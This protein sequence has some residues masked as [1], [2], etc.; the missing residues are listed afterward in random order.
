VLPDV[1]RERYLP[2]ARDRSRGHR[3][4]S[5]AGED[6]APGPDATSRAPRRPGNSS[7]A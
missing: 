7:S 2:L 5:T 1:L 4:L 6:N 3:A